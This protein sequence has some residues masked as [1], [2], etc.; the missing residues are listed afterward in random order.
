MVPASAVIE[1][2]LGETLT[3]A[4][5]P[6][7]ETIGA[8]TATF[9]ISGLNTTETGTGN[10]A[11]LVLSDSGGG[12]PETF[13]FSTTATSGTY[14]E[15]MN[16]GSVGTVTASLTFTDGASNTLTA[17][18]TP[19][20]TLAAE[21][22]SLS[23]PAGTLGSAGASAVNFVV[24]GD[25]NG[26]SGSL[27]LTDGGNSL[28]VSVGVNGT[29]TANLST[30]TNGVVSATLHVSDIY[31][32]SFSSGGTAALGVAP[33]LTA[34]ATVTFTA[35]T[36]TLDSSLTVTDSNSGGTL[37]GATVA[38]GAGFFPG[39]ML[40]FTN[41]N[42]ITGS[43]NAGTGVLSLTGPASV[44]NYQTALESI[45]FSSTSTNPTDWGADLNR[46][47]SWTV[48][49]GT[50]SSAPATSTVVLPLPPTPPVPTGTSADMILRDSTTGNYEIYDIGS[51]AIL[52]AA[53]LT[54][55]ALNWQVAGLGGFSGTDTSDMMLRDANTGAFAVYDVSN[56]KVT[57]SAALGTVGLEWQVSGFGDFSSN[58]AET[59]ML[60]QNGTTGAFEIYDISNN[61]ITS[62]A[63]LSGA[64]GAPWT[65]AGF[66]DFS[67]NPGESD[68][69][70][71]NSSTGAFEV[72]DISH[73][74]ITSSAAMGAIGLEWT[75]AGFGDFSGNANETDML[76]RNSNTGAF[77]VFDIG[78]NAIT[79]AVAL[80]PIG[81]E[82]QV[83]GFGDLSGNTNET[84]MLMQAT[85]GQDSGDFEYFDISRNQLTGAGPIGAA[86]LNWQAAG[87]ANVASAGAA[88]S[89]GAAGAAGPTSQLIQAMAAFAG[90]AGAAPGPAPAPSVVEGTAETSQHTLLTL[91][92]H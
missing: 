48:T 37:A 30:W 4:L 80:G 16:F 87:I 90:S 15:T 58:P 83:I 82:W 91:P 66:G 41:Q 56:N 92:P 5:S 38:I 85:S 70:M 75:V 3:L 74:A 76:L 88:V 21:T 1:P 62:A 7:T 14:I 18:G 31:G 40:N 72:Y 59:D 69:L 33:A 27:T 20:V 67:G 61:T 77:E 12:A 50:L 47:V 84:D 51:N 68:M 26:Q 65:V 8:E 29:Y 64:M 34:G 2:D 45:A 53:H 39:D 9:T 17:T 11:T 43:Y 13:S 78:N 24:T 79:S 46:T 6:A 57:S 49:D 10:T 81:P 52:A 55:V 44:A 19:N 28:T 54:Q 22:V 86:A 73:N 23:G 36:V 60:M 63:S 25:V 35:G 71:R 89:A 42:G 32:N